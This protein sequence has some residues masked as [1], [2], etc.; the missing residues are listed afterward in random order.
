MSDVD[1]FGDSGI[2]EEAPTAPIRIRLPDGQ[3]ILGRLHGRVQADT[4]AWFYQVSVSL[5]STVHTPQGGEVRAEPYDVSFAAPASH[6]QPVDG[7]YHT[8]V[9]VRRSRATPY[10]PA[11]AAPPP[12]P[13]P[14]RLRLSLR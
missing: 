9:P 13:R 3:Q 11:P 7:A 1:A 12:A 5:R 6:V 2:P 8:H 14:L 10:A 4:G